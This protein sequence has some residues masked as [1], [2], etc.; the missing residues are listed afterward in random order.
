V[1]HEFYK[2]VRGAKA[3]NFTRNGITLPRVLTFIDEKVTEV[4]VYDVVLSDLSRVREF[5]QQDTCVV[6]AA[7]SMTTAF[8][9]PR[10]SS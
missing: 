10:S 6:R 1:T 5:M 3:R 8:A 2:G 7:S 4:D 9:A